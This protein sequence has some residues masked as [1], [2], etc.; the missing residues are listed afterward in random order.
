VRWLSAQE[1]VGDTETHAIFA[2]LKE[3]PSGSL[4]R[5]RRSALGA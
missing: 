3:V 5:A 2:Q 1:Y 4:A